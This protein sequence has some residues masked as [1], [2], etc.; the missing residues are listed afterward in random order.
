[1][2]APNDPVE[3]LEGTIVFVDV[4]GFTRLSERLARKG[5]EG[6]EHLTDAINGCF[7][8]LLAD[9]Y[10]NG[11]S[12]LK[13]GG[14]ALLVWFEGDDH[15]LRACTAAMAMRTTLRRVGRIRAGGT[16]II[17]R[18]SAGVHTGN[19]Q[20]FL[21]GKSHRE[22]LIAG[23]D[24]TKAVEMEALASA[25]QVLVSPE[26]AASLPRRALGAHLGPGVLLARS[27]SAHNFAPEEERH[28]PDDDAV[29]RCLSTEVRAHVL[30]A[31]ATPE[32]RT[33]VVA[34]VQFGGL[35]E[36]ITEGGTSRAA[37]ALGELIDAVEEAAD[38]FQACFLGSDVAA[39]G[40]KLILTS[41][42]PRAVGDDA[43]RML[44]T[45][46]HIVEQPRQ[47]RVRVGV[48]R[49]RVFAGEIGP[50]YRRTYSVMGDTVN[51]AARLMAEAPWEAVYAT[52][53]VLT[54]SQTKFE[55]TRL[56]PFMVKG[57]SQPIEAWTVGGLARS[58]ASHGASE[59]VPLIGRDAEYA[60][61]RD[62]LV[63]AGRGKGAVIEIIGETGSGKSRLL[64]E[65]QH[66]ADGFRFAHTICENYRRSVPYVVWRDI[67]RQLLGLHWDDPDEV[68]AAAI[69]SQPEAVGRGLLPWLPLLA[70]AFDVQVP[71]TREVSD[72]GPDHRAAKL[73]E[74]VLR[75]LGPWLAVP[76]LIE[77]EHVHFMDDASVALLQ[78]IARQ[79]E[80]SSWVIAVT[81]RDVTGGFVGR[82]GLF[83]S[84]I[85]LGPLP[86][87][88]MIALAESTPEASRVPP[89]VLELAVERAG[90]SPE[91][92][93][94]LLAAA[95]DGSGEL[96]DSIDAAASARID[97]LD[98]RDRVLVRRASVLGL[99]FHRRLLR[100]VLDAEMPEPDERTWSRIT[101]VFADD[102][103]GYTRFKRPA[104]R[105][106]AYEGLPFRLRRR[107]HAAVGEAL[108][109]GLGRDAD[110]DPAVLSLH[111]ILAGDHQRAWQYA[112]MGAERASAR[113]AHADAAR[114]YRRALEAGREAR[115][116]DTDLAG[117]WEALGE[118]LAQ[119]GEPV[120]AGRALTAARRL[121]AGDPVTEARLYFRHGRIAEGSALSAALRWMRRGLRTL[122]QV[123]GREA[124]RW[125]ATM[126]AELAWIRQRQR[127]YRDAERLCREALSVGRSAGELR[128]EARACYTLDWALFEQGRAGELGHSSRALEIYRELGDPENEANVLNNL[129]GFAYWQ[130]RW[131]E[132]VGLYLQ[133]S[134]CSER[135]GNAADAADAAAN[136][137]E[138]RSD[139]GRLDEAEASLRR[140]VRVWS[141]T[142]QQASVA[143]ATMLL[144]RLAVRSGRP[145]EGMD[146]LRSAAADAR[147]F[148]FDYYAEL[149]SAV[150]A[151]GEALAGSAPDAVAMAEDLLSSG[152]R[153][154]S[155][156]HRARGIAFARIGDHEAADHELDLAAGSARERGE[157][158]ELALALDALGALRAP[159]PDL[160]RE[161]D[162][163]IERLGIVSL[164]T[165]PLDARAYFIQGSTAHLAGTL[166]TSVTV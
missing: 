28:S 68:V 163:I 31:P 26:T 16:E 70:I 2:V 123:P 87:N 14:D 22:F 137:G 9:A 78:A 111:F 112:R 61:L 100:Y 63:D 162:A 69:R 145:D 52:E 152:N 116:G 129:G 146:M 65:A 32:H 86:A 27:P 5:G 29:L 125:R 56:E 7:S 94:D 106:V 92:L 64:A 126:I 18:M 90:G 77:I 35:A 105:E 150:V 95:A 108:E 80:G 42:A 155:L 147:R 73:H 144:G 139:Q 133:A 115:V 141:S 51:L 58:R 160:E 72:L 143:F 127:R 118:A 54:R 62:A 49:G 121:I 12:L 81:R 45:L 11:G 103:D 17:L 36:L 44:L 1:V 8:T 135:S 124:A 113:F 3:T 50:H 165:L 131:E 140:A 154:V 107:L 19:F 138:I 89:H 120:A 157:D 75:F 38:L 93:L 134:A 23:P 158:F 97:E 164:P 114:M 83:S 30:A 153:Q 57:K 156:L 110:A 148:G 85:S 4:S 67:L 37:R 24:S 96:P 15:P 159:Q 21:V 6:A 119:V 40:G 46:R 117:V 53:G 128:A 55:R 132:A 71:M 84:Q 104:M 10:A 166:A 34:F 151:E 88:A 98:P 43:E 149:A 101:A 48:N 39:G 41:G 109:P 142:G 79:V 161:R 122:E 47:L 25:G 74:V 76:T 13:F 59:S 136:V 102:G 33:A 66:L 91:F 82:D 99:C 20:M 130:G 60:T